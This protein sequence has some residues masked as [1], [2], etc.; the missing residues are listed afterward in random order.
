MGDLDQAAGGSM[1]EFAERLRDIGGLS[2]LSDEGVKEP[3]LEHCVQEAS[4]RPEL[5][6]TPPAADA[7]EIRAL[8]RSA[9]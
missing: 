6:L 8:Y 5:H 3:D 2:R 7:D 9:G 1:V 4:G